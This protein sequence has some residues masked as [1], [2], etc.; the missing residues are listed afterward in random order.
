MSQKS[1]P[2]THPWSPKATFSWDE[3]LILCSRCLFQLSTV[4]VTR[5]LGTGVLG[6]VCSNMR[7]FLSNGLTLLV[8]YRATECLCVSYVKSSC[9]SWQNAS[10]VIS[11]AGGD[12]GRPQRARQCRA[13]SYVGSPRRLCRGRPQDSLHRAF[14]AGGS[15]LWLKVEIFLTLLHL[16]SWKLYTVINIQGTELPPAMARR[17]L[18]TH[19]RW[20][21]KSKYLDLMC[22][23]WPQL[24]NPKKTSPQAKR[25]QHHSFSLFWLF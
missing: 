6:R 16:W 12:S 4:K 8:R 10:E 18:P 19:I 7:E 14:H 24:Q 25:P 9:R 15:W 13:G 21:E 22:R 11:G 20:S 17:S 5:S 3:Q 23:W 2:I 1:S